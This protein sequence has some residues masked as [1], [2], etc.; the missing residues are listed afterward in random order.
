MTG[1]NQQMYRG[2]WMNI[3]KRNAGCIFINLCSR[4]F[5]KRDLAK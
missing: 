2:L 3:G 4:N 5:S 1:N